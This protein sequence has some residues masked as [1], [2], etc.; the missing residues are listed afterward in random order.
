ML[1][2]ETERWSG[3]LD[4]FFGKKILRSTGLLLLSACAAIAAGEEGKKPNIVLFV[5]REHAL[6]ILS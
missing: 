1:A 2:Q 3:A 5:L 4:L 6:L